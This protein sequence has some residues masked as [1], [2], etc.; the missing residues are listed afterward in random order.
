MIGLD[1]MD[2]EGGR[3]GGGERGCDLHADMARLAD[4]GDDDAPDAVA[5][6]ANRIAEGVALAKQAAADGRGPVVLA[7]HSDR[8]GYATWLLQEIVAQ[9]LERTLVATVASPDVVRFVI[10]SGAKP[11][12]AF[13]AEIGGLFDESAGAPIRITGKLRSIGPATTTRGNGKDWIC[14]EFGKGNLLVPASL[15]GHAMRALAEPG[16][17]GQHAQ[18]AKL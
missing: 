4:A 16:K 8:S 2:E 11:G 10:A 18:A 6:T 7:D 5:D 9:K 3:A 15:P 12:D 17:V 13:D 1:G 14:V